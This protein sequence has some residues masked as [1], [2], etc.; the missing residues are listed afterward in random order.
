MLVSHDLDEAVL[1]ADE[2]LLPTKRPTR[3]AENCSFDARAPAHRRHHAHAR[4]SS[5]PETRAGDLPAGGAQAMSAIAERHRCPAAPARGHGG[6][7]RP[8][9]LR[10]CDAPSTRCCLPLDGAS[11]PSERPSRTARCGATSTRPSCARSAL[12]P[13]AGDLG[14]AGHRAG[15]ERERSTSRSSSP[16][17][18]SARRRP[19][20]KACS[21]SSSCCS[22]WAR[23]TKI[24]VAA[25]G[26]ALAIPFNGPTA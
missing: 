5:P 16:S 24:A 3:V 2:V 14:A 20:R 19:R 22:A 13:G 25:F 21:R 12:R 15:L 10:P 6:A 9:G 11:P 17:T 18:S 1:L 26:A 23:A 8:L 4:P 7:D